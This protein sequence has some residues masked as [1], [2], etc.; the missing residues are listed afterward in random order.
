[1]PS[2]R[3][4]NPPTILQRAVAA[5]ARR[6]HSRAELARKLTRYLAESDDPTAI[7]AVLDQ[8]EAKGMLSD[9]RFAGALA[10][11]RGA[12]FG[13]ARIRQELCQRGVAPELI[14]KST[15]ALKQTEFE[16]ARD[17]WRRKF[18]TMPRDE[19]QRAKQMRFLTARGFSVDVVLRVIKDRPRRSE[20]GDD[21]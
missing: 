20:S 6:E 18:G 3:A 1:M 11:T 13:A 7:D 19:A 10:R 2:T 16:R 15:D 21:A 17:V 4:K 5:L 9:E 14:R 12:S 8:L